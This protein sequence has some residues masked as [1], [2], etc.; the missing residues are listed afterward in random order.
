MNPNPRLPGAELQG[1]MRVIALAK[2]TLK[3]YLQE[4]ILLV[5]MLF[6]ALLMLSSARSRKSWST[7]VSRPFR[8]SRCR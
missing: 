6:A 2:F 3:S 7:S 5:V 8:S 1:T 4:K